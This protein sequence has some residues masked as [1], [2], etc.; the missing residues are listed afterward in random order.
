MVSSWPQF[1]E[2]FGK[3]L[4]AMQPVVRAFELGLEKSRIVPSVD[5]ESRQEKGVATRLR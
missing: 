3:I 5:R 1:R 2:P 4:R